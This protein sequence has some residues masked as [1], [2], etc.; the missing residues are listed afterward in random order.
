MT[1]LMQ[2]SPFH[3]DFKIFAAVLAFEAH[4]F[5]WIFWQDHDD[6]SNDQCIQCIVTEFMQ[7][8]T[9]SRKLKT[10]QG[11]K[12]DFRVLCDVNSGSTAP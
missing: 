2:P 1:G 5:F 11:E 3:P 10:F 12:E 8:P 7:T 6:I 9:L 4:N